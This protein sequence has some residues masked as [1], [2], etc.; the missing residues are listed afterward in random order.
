MVHIKSDI[1]QII[2]VAFSLKHLELEFGYRRFLL[3]A[4]VM[5]QLVEAAW[6][7]DIPEGASPSYFTSDP[8]TSVVHKKAA[9]GS[10]MLASS[11]CVN[12]CSRLLTLFG[13]APAFT[14]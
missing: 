6:N 1:W 8:A 14:A 12:V 13:S 4:S 11:T 2:K 10:K 9:D 3:E 5:T 7:V